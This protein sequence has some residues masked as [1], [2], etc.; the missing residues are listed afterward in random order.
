MNN[1]SIKNDVIFLIADVMQSSTA[2]NEFSMYLPVGSNR[3]STKIESVYPISTLL[4]EYEINLMTDFA[5]EVITMMP[6]E[7]NNEQL[8]ILNK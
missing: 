8:V 5:K 3:F 7:D 2:L 4:L 1:V 6:I